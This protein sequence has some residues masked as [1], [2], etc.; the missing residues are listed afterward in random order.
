MGLTPA[1]S[2]QL[3]PVGG[4]QG[5]LLLQVEMGF[6]QGITICHDQLERL[7]IE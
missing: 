2:G 1:L 6:E 3:V 5:Y 7:L 4:G